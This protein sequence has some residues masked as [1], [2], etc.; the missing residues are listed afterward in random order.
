MTQVRFHFNVAD[1]TD[2][3]CRL[4]RKALRQGSRVAVVGPRAVLSGLD[5]ALWMFDA[6]EFV[7][8][9]VIPLG[10]RLPDRLSA[11]P[12][13]LAERATDAPMRDVLVNLGDDVPEGFESFDRIVEIVSTEGDDRMAAR[14]RWRAYAGKGLAIERHEVPS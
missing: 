4:L 10:Q 12:V 1:R 3:A 13:C 8:H 2:Y 7:P 9:A 6:L 14:Q 5:R 11:T